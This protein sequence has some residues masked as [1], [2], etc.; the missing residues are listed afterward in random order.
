MKLFLFLIALCLISI[1]CKETST[2]PNL[3]GEVDPG[4]RVIV[5]TDHDVM[6]PDHNTGWELIYKFS[7]PPVPQGNW[8]PTN[9]TVYAYGQVD[10]DMYGSSGRYSISGYQYNQIVPQV[11]IGNCLDSSDSNYNPY[12]S[13][14]NS[15]VMQAQYFWM[16]S[17][18]TVHSLCGNIVN[19]S[20]QEVITTRIAYSA[21]IGGFT[22]M[23]FGDNDTSTILIPQPFPNNTSLFAD[24]K[25]F[26]TQAQQRSGTSGPYSN[27]VLNVETHYLKA[28]TVCSMLPFRIK[29]VSIP[30][31]LWQEGSYFISR[32]GD[33]ACEDPQRNK[34]AI[35]EY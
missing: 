3:L 13:I 14:Y 9:Q 20:P 15:W 26:F 28:E 32:S 1:N 18:K 7:V 12:W 34:L 23:I 17:S 10:F 25:N 11:M 24:W 35:L 22:V 16:D 5:S 31:I 27:P 8:D 2:G 30:G 4:Y 29:H 33:Y 21:I 19:V 6:L